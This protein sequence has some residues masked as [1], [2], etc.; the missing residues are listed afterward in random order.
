MFGNHKNFFA[1][2]R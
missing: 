2:Q 1:M